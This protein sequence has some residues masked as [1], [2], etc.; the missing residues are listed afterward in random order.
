MQKL[1]G[2]N[3]NFKNR[4]INGDF[5][6]W[7]R[8]ENFTT[9]DG[10]LI[11]TADRF[12]TFAQNGVNVSK[13]DNSYIWSLG[14]DTNDYYYPIR[15]RFEGLHLYDLAK[16]GNKITISFQ[17]KT[18]K[19]GTYAIAL[20]HYDQ[21][22]TDNTESLI[23][24]FEVTTANTFV[25]IEVTFDLSELQYTLSNNE[26]KEFE[27]FLCAYSNNTDAQ[28]DIGYNDGWKVTTANAT[29]LTS[30]D[31]LEFKELQLEKGNIATEFEVVP[32]D[33]QLQRCMRYCRKYG[34]NIGAGVCISSDAV[35]VSN[36]VHGM[37]TLPTIIAKGN[38]NIYYDGSAVTDGV[39]SAGDI[40]V[41]KFT[42]A[43]DKFT[44]GEACVG[45]ASTD[46]YLLY[47]AEL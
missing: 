32:Y 22:D 2:S 17:F 30:S 43:S 5:S 47:D 8:G 33:I 14:D 3:F 12:F 39:F 23:A 19:T 6:V 25:K 11:Y 1:V 37:R 13:G 35:R 7:Q 9:S 28:G 24:E 42:S 45:D 18:T 15:Y 4:I 29:Q 20:V 27:L 38:F 46:S 36:K 44:T 34:G 21:T 16:N 10:S 31:T 40:K 26:N 41:L